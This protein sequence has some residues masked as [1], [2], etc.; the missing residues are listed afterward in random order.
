TVDMVESLGHEALEAGDGPE[1]IALIEAHPDIDVLLTDLGL[2]GM[3]GVEMVG[4]VRAMRPGLKIIIASGYST[5]SSDNAALPKDVT[6]LPKPYNDSQLRR[7]FEE[8]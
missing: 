8:D 5:E 3:S 2:P 1:A 7:A 6:F 4:R